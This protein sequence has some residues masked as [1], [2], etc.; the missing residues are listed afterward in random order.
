MGRLQ[1][2][3]PKGEP[4]GPHGNKMEVLISTTALKSSG[5]KSEWSNSSDLLEEKGRYVRIEG[6]RGRCRPALL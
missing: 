2:E 6:M 5:D 3:A 4:L 1:C